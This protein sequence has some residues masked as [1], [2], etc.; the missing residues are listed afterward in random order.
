MQTKFLPTKRIIAAIIVLLCSKQS[1]SQISLL[2]DYQNNFSAPIGLYQGINFREAGFSALYAIPNTNGT[3][4]WTVSDRGPNVDCANANPAACRPT[5]DKMFPFP[6]FAPKIH[7]IRVKGDSIQ[8]L[9][10]ITMKRPSGSNATGVMNPAGFGSTALEV[11]STDTV[12]DC[13]NFNAKTAPKD[14]WGIDSEGILVDKYGNFWICEEGG[15]TVWMLSPN[16]VVLKRYSPYANLAGAQPQ[17]VLRESP[18]H[19][20]VKFMLLYKAR[21][22]TLMQIQETRHAFTA[23]WKSTRLTMPCVCL[24][25]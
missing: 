17:E 3:E 19:P 21:C 24:F 4:Y 11:V 25:M 12:L 20:M 16:G 14:I 6:N 1:Q 10:T 9:Q 15:P 23:S 8:I 5:Y 18:L 7:R 13:A 22:C 2:Q